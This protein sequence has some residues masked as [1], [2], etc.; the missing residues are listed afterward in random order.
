MAILNLDHCITLLCD[1]HD[2]LTTLL[3]PGA[4]DLAKDGDVDQ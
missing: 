1:D 2:I 4:R 3:T